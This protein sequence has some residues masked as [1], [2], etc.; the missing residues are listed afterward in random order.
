MKL[1]AGWLVIGAAGAVVLMLAMDEQLAAQAEGALTDITEGA[2]QAV[3]SVG[4]FKISRMATVD[5]SLVNNPQVRAM[6]A[7]I[8]KGEGTA[9]PAGYSRVFG[10]GQ[11]SGFVDHPRQ[12]VTKWGYTS[13]AAGAYQ[14]L[15]SVWDET[16]R[17][18]GL[19]DFS[20]SSQDLFALGRIAARGALDDVLAGNFTAAVRKLGREW[21]SLPESPYGQGTISWATARD[22]FGAAGGRAVA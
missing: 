5:K 3:D 14:A 20:P 11:F 15:A 16:K 18:M 13:T 8:R 6:L 9:D 21:A 19:R 17:L 7:V 4:V 1:D 12:S 2:A 10:G 22:T